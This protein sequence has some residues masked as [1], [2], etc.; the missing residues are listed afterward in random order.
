MMN[1]KIAKVSA[2]AALAAAATFGL[3]ACTTAAEDSSSSS[4][5]TSQQVAPTIVDVA[6]LDGQTIDIN[7]G[8][9]IDITTGD[10]DPA[11]WTA[12]LSDPSVATFTEGSTGTAVMNPGLQGAKAGSTTVELTNKTTG[13][14]V[15]FTVNVK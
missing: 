3:S 15:T 11:D 5:E 13:A 4:S 2:I 1:H 12:V 7:N 14:V 9:F 6:T 8:N 10:T